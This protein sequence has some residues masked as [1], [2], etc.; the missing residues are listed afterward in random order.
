VKYIELEHIFDENQLSDPH[1]FKLTF[2]KVI[3]SLTKIAEV[4]ERFP[5]VEFTVNKNK[6]SFPDDRKAYGNIAM[7][8][9]E[10]E[11]LL[12]RKS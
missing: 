2:D 3:G 8:K 7:L 4:A 11:I 10:F 9:K 1:S 5:V 6:F 12:K